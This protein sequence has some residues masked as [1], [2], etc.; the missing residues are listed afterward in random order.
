MRIGPEL[1]LPRNEERDS[2]GF[3]AESAR[4]GDSFRY[5]HKE[6]EKWLR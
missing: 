6:D 3:S 1:P 2:D 4:V 5:D